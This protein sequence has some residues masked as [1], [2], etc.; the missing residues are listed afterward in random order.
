MMQFNGYIRPDGSV[1]VRNYVLIMPVV[2][3]MEGVARAIAAQLDDAL[4]VS[5]EHGCLYGGNEQVGHGMVG[6]G[7]NP[8]AAAVLLLG[9]GCE[10]F[11][12]SVIATPLEKTG[13]PVRVLSALKEGGIRRTFAKGLQIARELQDYAKSVQRQ[14]ADISALT[15]AVKCGG[16]DTSSG[17]ASNPSVGQAADLLVDAG[18]KVLFSEPIEMVD[19]EAVL[20]ALA[21]TPEVAEDIRTLVSQEEKRWSVPGVKTEFMCMGNVLGGLTSIEEKSLGSILKSGSKPIKGVLPFN[22]QGL[23]K[24]TEAGLYIQEGTHWDPHAITHFAAA[25]AQIILFTTGF[26]ACLESPL[27]PTIRV[28]G[29]PESIATVGDDIDVDASGIM[30]GTDSI[31]AVGERILAKILAAANGER[32]RVEGLNNVGFS[33][34]NKDQRLE[35]FLGFSG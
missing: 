21:A 9:M 33:F 6:I 24:P 8:N 1:G 17:L 32:T 13:K 29:N 18:A 35:H 23:T 15:V 30:L 34:Y 22:A 14:P 19:G 11:T 20:A 12:P 3:C 26:G 10:S 7:A 16:S 5:Q 4:V 2:S 27:S 25:G 31:E 28:S